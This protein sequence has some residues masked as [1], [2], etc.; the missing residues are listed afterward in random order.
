MP[1]ELRIFIKRG[2]SE[3]SSEEELFD[4]LRTSWLEHFRQF[5]A[6]KRREDDYLVISEKAGMKK[7]VLLIL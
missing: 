6:S 2:E 4:L 7:R 1:Y 5:P 3:D